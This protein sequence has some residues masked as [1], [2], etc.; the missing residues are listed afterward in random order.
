MVLRLWPGDIL[1]LYFVFLVKKHAWFKWKD[2]ISWF[3]ISP[4]SAEALVRRGGK[5][6]I[7]ILI[8]YFLSNICAKNC[9]NR[10]V[11]ASCRGGTFFE[12]QC[13]FAKWHFHFK[14]SQI[15]HFSKA[16]GSEN[17]RLAL[18]SEK[19]MATMFAASSMIEILKIR[20][21]TSKPCNG[22]TWSHTKNFR[23]KGT[24]LAF[25]YQ[26]KCI[27]CAENTCRKLY[28]CHRRP[29]VNVQLSKFG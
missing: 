10:A 20:W 4:G 16:F 5:I 8:A 25:R 3:P 22:K 11:L 13:R 12:T 28:R 7:Y 19:H 6:N 27:R 1:K 9:R 26:M 29:F 23:R 18:S 24:L 2:A 17:H 15:W 21:A 14:I